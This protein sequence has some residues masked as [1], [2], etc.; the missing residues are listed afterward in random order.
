MNNPKNLPGDRTKQEISVDS[1]N[2]DC[3]GYNKEFFPDSKGKRQRISAANQQVAARATKPNIL[4]KNKKQQMF[5]SLVLE[6]ATVKNKDGLHTILLGKFKS[7]IPFRD[8]VLFLFNAESNSHF[9]FIAH[10]EQK[11]TE[12]N[13]ILASLHALSDQMLNSQTQTQEPT[14]FSINEALDIDLTPG[15]I[16]FL[17]SVGINE[18]AVVRIAEGETVI[19]R[20]FLTSET[21]GNFNNPVLK[22]I[23]EISDALHLGIANVIKNE[24]NLIFE[25]EKAMLLDLSNNI[26]T[27]RN[28]TQLVE[29]VQREVNKLIPSTEIIISLYDNEQKTYKLFLNSSAPNGADNSNDQLR[30]ESNFFFDDKIGNDVF[31]SYEPIV[32]QVDDYGFSDETS[33]YIRFS[34]EIGASEFV[35]ITM[36]DGKKV[37]GALFLFSRQKKI[38]HEKDLNLLK[39]IA[40]QLSFA[41]ANILANE[42]L[43]EKEKETSILLAISKDLSAIRNK[44]DF[45]EMLHVRLKEIFYFSQTA[46]TITDIVNQTYS[47]FIVD[48][49]SKILAT[50]PQYQRI[51]SRKYPLNDSIMNVV[52]D[53]DEPLIFNVDELIQAGSYPEWVKM[54]HESGIQEI[55]ITRLTAGDRHIGTFAILSDKKNLIHQKHLNLIQGV[56]SQLSSAVANILANEELLQRE[57]EKSVLLALGINVATIRKKADLHTIINEKLK[58]LLPISHILTCLISEDRKSYSSFNLDSPSAGRNY[59]SYASVI[60]DQYPIEDGIVNL[61]LSAGH[62]VIFSLE[63]LI[64]RPQ[65]PSFLAMNYQHGIKEVV[66]SPLSHGKRDAGILILFINKASQINNNELNLIQGVSAQLS[67]AIANI[68]AN[69]EILQSE[70]EK[71]D[72]LSFSSDIAAVRDKLG[73]AQVISQGLKSFFKIEEY[74]L[75]ARN[76]DGITHS[77]FIYQLSAAFAN[78]AQFVKIKDNKFPISSGLAEIIFKSEGPVI[79]KI[80]DILQ[81]GETK[82]PSGPLWKS[83]GVKEVL[84]VPLRAGNKDIGILWTFP[85]QFNERLMQGISSQIAIALS[86]TI[87]M[88]KIENQFAQIS[89][90][91]QQLEVE[92]LYLQEEIHTT[93]NY[94]EI[95]GISPG[96]RSVF[97]LVSQVAST[98]TSVLIL[99]ETG[100]GKE[101]IAR[102]LHNA[103]PRKN[104]LMIKVNCATL[105]ANLIES[106]LF[107]HEKGSFTGATER[108]IGKFELANNSTLFLDE[109]GELPIDLQVKLLRALQEK[110]I[111]RVGGRTVIKTDVRIIAATNRS[112]QKE[113]AKGNFRSDL[114]FRLNVFPITLPPLRERKEDISIL[115]SHF[116]LKHAKKGIKGVLNF[117]SKVLKQLTA[118]SW[119]GNVRELEHLI[120]RSILLANGPTIQQVFLPAF[121]DQDLDLMPEDA[122]V[123]TIDEVERD[124]ILSVL[125]KCN[126]KI[127]G[128]GGAAEM[129]QIPSTTLNS[130][131]RRLKIR[132]KF[133]ER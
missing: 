59:E 124:H 54:N 41:T 73:L 8:I 36:L 25:W 7:L 57:N 27:I 84:G 42:E 105:P 108:R 87:A 56:S 4:Q 113:V 71:T 109:I 93:H 15:C 95:I 29:V 38:Y 3:F 2:D 13:K 128:F 120:E 34:K 89:N 52:L 26:A 62:P 115:A 17:N 21:T 66:Y 111:E 103:S 94:S 127:A 99:G 133:I 50:N 28:R 14:I 61:V 9:C 48:P 125:R 88:E 65:A 75:S 63:E 32:F 40:G 97:Q 74:L 86:N 129:L 67:T 72:L 39:G 117:S 82:Y 58:K 11:F 18:L 116:L 22:I 19:G 114:Y 92:N 55:I 20:L 49:N 119:P 96:M 91:K 37:L 107:G 24:E 44:G 79:F 70:T 81:Q 83:L 123:K 68:I 78:N 46:T 110:E 85:K 76:D 16:G 126:G 80:D 77:Y 131:I 90:Y 6:L 60:H 23:N 12:D 53:S 98:E 132:K 69:E 35:G 118:Y 1:V 106:E 122:L 102:A 43:I 112:L 64:G 30:S 101:L 47:G 130:K 121:E 51:V 31:K 104:K 45:L 10:F 33:A 100:T 5:L